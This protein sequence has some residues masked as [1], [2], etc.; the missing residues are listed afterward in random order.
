MCGNDIDNAIIQVRRVNCIQIPAEKKH[1][2]KNAY[3]ENECI[4]FIFKDSIKVKWR[5][6]FL[7]IKTKP[8]PLPT[9][10]SDQFQ[11]FQSSHHFHPSNQNLKQIL[12]FFT[13]TD[14][15]IHSTAYMQT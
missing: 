6:P 5:Q 15:H 13:S 10:L 9:A 2:R 8:K 12:A 11:I 14:T 1:R 4:L 3:S 7:S